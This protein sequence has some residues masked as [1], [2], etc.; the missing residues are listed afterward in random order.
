MIVLRGLPGSGKST[1]CRKIV[2]TY[3]KNSKI[4][5]V[6]CAGDEF[7]TDPITGEYKFDPEKLELAHM[8]AQ[9]KASNA[10]M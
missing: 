6:V 1:L 9:E 2:E 10:C 4:D 8:L 7:F 3:S 5:V